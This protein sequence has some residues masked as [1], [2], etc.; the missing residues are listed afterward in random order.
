MTKSGLARISA[1]AG[2]HLLGNPCASVI[3]ADVVAANPTG[4]DAATYVYAST[5]QYAGQYTAYVNGVGSGHNIA[6][7]QSFFKRV[8][9]VGA[10]NGQVSFTN[11]ARLTTYA[12]TAFQRATAETRTLVQLDLLNPA[13]QQRDAAYV[14]F[15]AGATAGSDAAFDAYKLPSGSGTYLALTTAAEPLAVSGLALPGT[16]DVTV[17]LPVAV[18][19]TGTYPLPA[20]QRP[21]LP[22][23]KT[24]YLRDT[25]TGAVVDLA[26]QPAYSFALNAA[27]AGP[28]FELVV[29]RR[30]LL[31]PAP[32]ALNA[33]VAVCPN[34]AHGQALVELPA[35]LRQQ[36]PT[37]T[38][39]NALGQTVKSVLLPATGT[40]EARS[41]PL[42]GVA[43][44][45]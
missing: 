14:Y 6:S 15:Q 24:A 38:L 31:A 3:D 10:T 20:G 33:Q 19:T 7:G 29:S 9:T 36:P 16:A 41:L 12:A 30:S 11:A 39:V 1:L 26:Q 13:N 42:T 34:P 22:A 40:A 45:V 17:P 23:G 25:Q 5:G 27:F 4:L 21:N 18:A 32:A 43:A 2:G 35:A 8:T 44:G 37:L 28:R